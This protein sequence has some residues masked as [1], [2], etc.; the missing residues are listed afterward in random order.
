MRDSERQRASDSQSVLVL[1]SFCGSGHVHGYLY[2]N[3]LFLRVA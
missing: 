2:G 3:S 1:R